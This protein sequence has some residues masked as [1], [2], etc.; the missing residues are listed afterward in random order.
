MRFGQDL[1]LAIAR[2]DCLALYGDLGVGK[3]TLARALIR[4]VADDQKLD[5]PSPTFTLV[6]SYELRIKLAHFD[7]YRIADPDEL[8]ELGLDDALEEGAVLI[9]WPERAASFLPDNAIAIVLEEDGSGRRALVSGG[10]EVMDRINRTLA[11]R[12][13]IDGAGYGDAQRCHFQGD[14]STRTYETIRMQGRP[15]RLLM[16]ERLLMPDRLLMNAPKRLLGPLMAGGRRYAQIAHIAEDVR[17]FVAIGDFLKEQG[18]H[19]PEIIARDMDAGFL[20]LEDLGRKT[21]L[22]ASGKPIPARWEAAIDCLVALHRTD[23]PASIPLPGE[24]LYDIP[25]FDR[26]AMLV[27]VAL[28]LQWYYP[29]VHNKGPSAQTEKL[30]HACWNEIIDRLEAAEKSLVLRDFHSPNILWQGDCAGIERIGLID[31]QDAMIGPAAY[32]VASLVQDARVTVVPQL[33]D[34]LVSRYENARA[35]EPGFD[36]L[37]FRQALAM[38]E[39]QRA[40]KILG[41]FVRLDKRDGKPA[42]MKHLPRIE[43]YLRRAFDHPVL[44]P[45]RDCYDK[46]GFALSES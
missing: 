21:M 46:I 20:L 16:P 9:E 4:S 23:I 42:Y 5:V 34:Q 24:A 40:T 45:L 10:P 11:A 27:E 33:H 25:A 31:F 22:D 3:S 44:Y 18:F 1:A 37:A 6:Q 26:E 35:A 38:M 17:P 43:A 30:F 13:F 29:H 14:A 19:T 41:I 36:P 12:A 32:D 7:L 15:D 39:A 28:F 8:I 2:G